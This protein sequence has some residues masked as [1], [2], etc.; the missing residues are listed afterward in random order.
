MIIHPISFLPMRR[1]PGLNDAVKP[2][3]ID[4]IVLDSLDQSARFQEVVGGDAELAGHVID[5]DG[6]GDGNPGDELTTKFAEADQLQPA[7]VLRQRI[8]VVDV[9]KVFSDEP[10]KWK[11]KTREMHRY[12]KRIFDEENIFIS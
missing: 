4:V 10:L 7:R 1:F 6:F 11:S 8:E 12:L 3:L 5:I 9:F 2:N